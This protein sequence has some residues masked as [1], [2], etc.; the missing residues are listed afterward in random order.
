[1]ISLRND[2]ILKEIGRKFLILLWWCRKKCDES[3]SPGRTEER[4]LFI[5]EEDFKLI[6][7]YVVL[8]KVSSTTMIIINLPTLVLLKNSWLI[9]EAFGL[10]LS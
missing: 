2:D 6:N 1:M 10:L 8:I 7:E 5:K 3:Y 4:S 9:E